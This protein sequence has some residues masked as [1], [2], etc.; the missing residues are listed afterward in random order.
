MDDL[1]IVNVSGTAYSALTVGFKNPGMAHPG[2]FVD[3]LNSANPQIWTKALSLSAVIGGYVAT[4]SVPAY[5]TV[6]VSLTAG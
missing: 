2:A 4:I 5:S 1:L 6:A 3:T